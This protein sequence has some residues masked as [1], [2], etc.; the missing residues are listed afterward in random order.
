MPY[1]ESPLLKTIPWIKHGFFT[2]EDG[3]SKGIYEGR[4]C[5]PG[6]SDQLEHIKANRNLVLEEL[7][8]LPLI[9]LLSCYQIHSNQTITVNTPWDV[10]DRANCPQADA[11]IANQEETY[12]GILTADCTPILFADKTQPIIA[13]AHAGWK[14]AIS[15]IIE[16][17]ISEMIK[18][19]A[20]IDNIVVS[21]GPSIAQHSYEVG[22]E[23]YDN[24]LKQDKTYESFFLEK[25]NSFY[26]D[27]KAFVASKLKE[28][29]IMHFDIQPQDTY[30][31]EKKFYSFR[32][33]THRSEKDY[34]RQISMI[35]IQK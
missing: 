19:G 15:G 1:I 20:K 18:K 31:D 30:A 33:T 22:Q 12:L 34:G 27:L 10:Y 26:F 25:E 7:D 16:N 4:N 3:A 29:G 2:R 11:M 9:P 17:T 32:R 21:I 13:A 35:G 8:A 6:S 28:A 5:G 14:G 23:F 24:F